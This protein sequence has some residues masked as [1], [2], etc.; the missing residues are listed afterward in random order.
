[1]SE[2]SHLPAGVYLAR[3]AW[4]T[5]PTERVLLAQL[6]QQYFTYAFTPQDLETHPEAGGNAIRRDGVIA[7]YVCFWPP[8]KLRLFLRLARLHSW[9]PLAAGD[10]RISSDGSTSCVIGK[11]SSLL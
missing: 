7:P 9:P 1:M 6:G 11:A 5:T 2:L 3:R 8:E 4:R 10:F